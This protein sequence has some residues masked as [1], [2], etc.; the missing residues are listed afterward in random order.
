MLSIIRRM[1]LPL[2]TLPVICPIRPDGTVKL[3]LTDLVAL[4]DAAADVTDEPTLTI[5]LVVP[6]AGLLEPFGPIVVLTRMVPAMTLPPP[7]LVMAI[8]WPS[9]E[10]TLMAVA[11]L[12]LSGPLTVTMDL[13]M[14]R[15]LELVNLVVPRSS[16]GPLSPTMVR[17]AAALALMTRVEQTALPVSAIRTRPVLETIRPPAMT[18]FPLSTTVLEF[19]VSLLSAVMLTDIIELDILPVI[20]S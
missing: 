1:A 13:F 18:Q 17:L 12:Q 2:T 4:E 9:V 14:V 3:T 20:V 11:L 15:P 8:G 7:L 5:R 16:G 6:K 19:P 10:M